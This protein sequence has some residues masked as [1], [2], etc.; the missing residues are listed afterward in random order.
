MTTTQCQSLDGRQRVMEAGVPK[1]YG[2]IE[3]GCYLTQNLVSN[4]MFALTVD[5]DTGK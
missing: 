4:S 3:T 5:L 1:R 2:Q